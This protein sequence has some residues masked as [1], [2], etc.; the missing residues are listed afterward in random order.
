MR[1]LAITKW[2]YTFTRA[3]IHV[4]TGSTTWT[5]L[6][7]PV[8][9]PEF[10]LVPLNFAFSIRR[11]RSGELESRG[12][13]AEAADGGGGDAADPQVR[14][15]VQAQIRIQGRWVLYSFSVLTEIGAPTL[16]YLFK[17]YVYSNLSTICISQIAKEHCI[18]NFS[19]NVL[20]S[21]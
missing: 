12:G 8:V 1:I 16:F 2:W 19:H 7:L 18:Q 11:L 5:V 20:N 3:I 9:S 14:V 10:E 17:Q 21:W 15:H 6:Q 4:L 13:E